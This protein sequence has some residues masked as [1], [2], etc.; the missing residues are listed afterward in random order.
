MLS[1]APLSLW[2]SG[3]MSGCQRRRDRTRRFVLKYID[4]LEHRT[5]L[6][7]GSSGAHAVAVGDFNGD[8]QPDLVTANHV[9][10]PVSALIN[11]TPTAT[12]NTPTPT[13]FPPTVVGLQYLGAR[14]QPIT[15]VLTF[16]EPMNAA[17]A[18]D[19]A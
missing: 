4:V 17:R 16:S 11:N 19:R 6:S 12:F 13:A 18:E 8:G 15:L 9:G 5:L 2:A 10:S 14:N 7:L 1:V 3:P